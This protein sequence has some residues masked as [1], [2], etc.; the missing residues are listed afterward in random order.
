MQLAA[1]KDLYNNLVM[2]FNVT[3]EQQIQRKLQHIKEELNREKTQE[4]IQIHTQFH[5]DLSAEQDRKFNFYCQNT[6]NER[7]ELRAQEIREEFEEE[8]A[9]YLSSVEAT[10]AQEKADLKEKYQLDLEAATEQQESEIEAK[11]RFQFEAQ[12]VQQQGTFARLLEEQV[13]LRTQAIKSEAEAGYTNVMNELQRTQEQLLIAITARNKAETRADTADADYLALQEQITGN[14]KEIEELKS[15]AR[16]H[17]DDLA[18]KDEEAKQRERWV[19]ELEGRLALADRL[20]EENGRSTTRRITRL[21]DERDDALATSEIRRVD[22]L[23]AQRDQQDVQKRYNAL[24]LRRDNIEQNKAEFIRRGVLIDQLQA[25]ARQ[26]DVRYE[27]MCDQLR[28][29]GD[30]MAR[31]GIEPPAY[32]GAN[33]GDQSPVDNGLRGI[34]S[35]DG[36]SHY[37]SSLAPSSPAVSAAGSQA[38]SQAGSDPGSP[39]LSLHDGESSDS[40]VSA[41]PSPVLPPASPVLPPPSPV[42]SSAPGSP[43][44]PPASPIFP[45]AP[46]AVIILAPPAAPAVIILA[47]R[48]PLT[49]HNPFSC[50]FSVERYTA[51]LVSAGVQAAYKYARRAFNVSTRTP[52]SPPHSPPIPP[53]RTPTPG[54]PA[55]P[56]GSAGLADSFH[57]APA[58]S[59]QRPQRP[60]AAAA[61]N[62]TNLSVLRRLWFELCI[63]LLPSTRGEFGIMGWNIF[64]LLLHF[65]VYNFIYYI[66]TV[67]REGNFWIDGNDTARLVVLDQLHFRHHSGFGQGWAHFLLSESNAQTWDYVWQALVWWGE[68]EPVAWKMAG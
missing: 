52:L 35:D 4:I 68:G 28:A 43:V 27:A 31:L 10:A 49:P 5:A 3:V 64:F 22:A 60:V 20:N 51:I 56:P 62:T 19:M 15:K 54:S 40:D 48:D 2:T 1:A 9:E 50:W 41:P 57:T 47:A 25:E 29:V 21:T 36:L 13:D 8:T 6:I 12:S 16:E 55:A 17:R 7:V 30:D 37:T 46:P 61:A 32:D 67:Y 23:N 24:L 38:G 11:Y 63:T 53:P 39:T 33:T 66:Y 58:G 45:P 18:A 14:D 42:V 26:R 59:P 65:L 34:L 44:Q